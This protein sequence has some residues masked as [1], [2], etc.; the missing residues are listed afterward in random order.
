MIEIIATTLEDAVKIQHCGGNRIELVSALSE[1]GLTPSY[2]LIKRVVNGVSIPVNVIIRPHANSFMYTK[3]EIEIMKEDIMI[4]KSLKVNGVVFGILDKR[5]EIDEEALIELLKV[6]DGIDVTF[7]RAIDELPNPIYGMKIL[8]K[9]P[10]IKTVLT[11]GGKGPISMNIDTIKKMMESA[12]H[13]EV[14]V[15]GGL[16]FENIADIVQKTKGRQ[17]HFGT[18]VREERSPLKPILEEKAVR[19]VSIVEVLEERNK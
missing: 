11:S 2:A 18:V 3:E 6:C 7:H 16:N 13:I 5:N 12:Q 8:V 19:I 1:G 4:A 17:Y 14:M 10:Q 9:Y 15:G